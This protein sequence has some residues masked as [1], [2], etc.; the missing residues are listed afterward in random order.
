[1]FKLVVISIF[2]LVFSQVNATL[3]EDAL[4]NKV[5]VVDLE[6]YL[7]LKDA[8][9]KGAKQ[10]FDKKEE[11]SKHLSSVY[12]VK[13][14]AERAREEGLLKSDYDKQKLQQLIDKFYFTLKI[15]QVTEKNLPNF[16]PLAKVKYSANK[17]EYKIP[18]QVDVAHI[19]L[20]EDKRSKNEVM[21]LLDE[22]QKKIKKGADFQTLADEYS[23]DPTI[24][25]NHGQLGKLAKGKLVKEFEEVAFSLKKGEISKPIKTKFG[26]HII[27]LNKHYPSKDQAFSEVK[28][29][30]IAEI[31][32]SYVSKRREDYFEKVKTENK[33]QLNGKE[34]DSYINKKQKEYV[35]K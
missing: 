33:M 18:A 11:V 35:P 27:K 8:P 3:V 5:Q 17:Q 6:A 34:I 19:M 7:S 9:K 23:E 10:L 28:E 16:E 14:I 13:A 32:A 24:K 22:I 1:M 29:K 30:I 26:Y 31:K 12:L 20:T 4:G 2:S 15:K 21:I 25:K